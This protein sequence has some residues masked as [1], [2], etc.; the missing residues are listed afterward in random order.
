MSKEN[1]LKRIKE[2]PEA[3]KQLGG[4]LVIM[5]IIFLSF[6]V[7]NNIFGEGDELVAKMKIYLISIILGLLITSSASARSTGCKEGN[8]ENGYGKWVY[9]DKTT[10]EGEWVG[11]KK[12]GQGTETWPNGY[13]YKGEFK[14]SLWTG[15]GTLTFP[16]GST[17]EGEWANGFMNGEGTFTWSDGTQKSGTWKNGELQE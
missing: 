5:M 7:L 11:T 8:C 12:H 6:F 2:L 9:T 17:Y 1:Y 15:L 13:I 3:I 10:Y 16:D 4:L 14:N